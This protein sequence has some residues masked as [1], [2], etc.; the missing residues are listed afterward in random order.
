MVYGMPTHGPWCGTRTYPTTCRWCHQSVYFFSCS[1]G[2]KVFFDELGGAWPIHSCNAASAVLGQPIN[3]PGDLLRLDI[4]KTYAA[5]IMQAAMQLHWSSHP[6]IPS[7]VQRA[8]VI[9]KAPPNRDVRRRIPAQAGDWASGLGVLRVILTDVD[10]LKKVGLPPSSTLG[11]ALLKPFRGKPMS[12]VTIE[13]RDMAST[14]GE[15]F[16]IFVPSSVLAAGRFG[17]GQVVYFQADGVG[18]PAREAF[19]T[20]EALT[21]PV[22]GG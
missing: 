12:Q 20:C 7:Q 1:H 3:G 4:D 11:A 10:V 21:R 5:L 17:V 9:P 15:S 8:M 19:W 13:V 18:V 6:T 14:G 16:T 2:S 22:Y